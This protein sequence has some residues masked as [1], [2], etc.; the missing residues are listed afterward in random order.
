MRLLF[1]LGP[2]LLL[3]GSACRRAMDPAKVAA[4]DSLLH[5][6][7][8]LLAEV[9]A[10]DTALYRNMAHT[11][12]GQRAWIQER[13]KD[14]L[15]RATANV[16]GPYH[17]AMNKSVGRVEKYYDKVK[18]ELETSR[19]KLTDLRRDVER[20]LWEKHQE[21]GYLAEERMIM[22][23]LEHDAGVLLR[24]AATA[25]REWIHRAAVDSM[26]AADTSATSTPRP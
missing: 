6:A 20:G 15:D 26:I 17:R 19:G 11:Y 23:Q 2:L 14:T 10:L 1:V 25:G 5:T 24:S 21:D 8:S 16:L 18:G 4:I 7:D 13:F 9:N 22:G 3:A 12:A